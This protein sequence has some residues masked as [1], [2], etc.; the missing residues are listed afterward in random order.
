M[1]TH[2]TQVLNP[3]IFLSREKTGT[4]MEQRLKEGPPR[5]QEV[6]AD[7]NL[8]GC[9]LRV[10]SSNTQMLMWMLE[11]R[12]PGGKVEDDSGVAGDFNPIALTMSEQ[13]TQCSHHQR[14]V[15]GVI[16]GSRY[17]RHR[18]GPC[19]L[20]VSHSIPR[21]LHNVSKHSLNAFTCLCSPI[22]PYLCK[23]VTSASLFFK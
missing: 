4:N 14:S 13:T 16:H 2:P 7:R 22:C 21:I 3:E 17:T 19:L 12:D 20:S 9:S 23:P 11:L 15:Q 10:S 18:G 1:A 6:L 8:C 5:D